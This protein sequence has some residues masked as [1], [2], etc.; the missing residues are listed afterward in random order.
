LYCLCILLLSQFKNICTLL[1][2]SIVSLN[3]I[4]KPYIY[5]E[6]NQTRKNFQN[7]THAFICRPA[8]MIYTPE[9]LTFSS[10]SN[11]L[12]ISYSFRLKLDKCSIISHTLAGQKSMMKTN[13]NIKKS[14]DIK[15]CPL[16]KFHQYH[17]MLLNS[18]NYLNS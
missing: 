15:S 10:F 13:I 7:K 17:S 16:S 11:F 5:A 2:Y 6:S 4:I 8:R 3:T 14:L 1:S 18:I 9:R 12:S